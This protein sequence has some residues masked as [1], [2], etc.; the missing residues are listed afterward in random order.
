MSPQNHTAA[1]PSIRQDS[2]PFLA[3]DD[4]E[5][6]VKRQNI[7]AVALCTGNHKGVGEPKRQIGISFDKLRH[8]PEILLA[9]VESKVRGKAFQES[10]HCGRAKPRLDQVTDLGQ[11]SGGDQM[12]SSVYEECRLGPGVLRV[13]PVGKRE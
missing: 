9:A 10:Q 6:I 1:L 8:A 5:I 3:S 7:P 13:A 4:K 12:R 2:Q 11:N